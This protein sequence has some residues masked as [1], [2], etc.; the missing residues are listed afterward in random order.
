[1]PECN[2]LTGEHCSILDRV[3]LSTA[4]TADL[5]RRCKE[6]GLPVDDAEQQN[7]AQREIARRIKASFFPDQL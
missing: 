4:E 3:L 2:P 5:I 7:T 1:M 6:C